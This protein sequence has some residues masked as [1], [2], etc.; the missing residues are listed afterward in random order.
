M[1]DPLGSQSLLNIIL[2]SSYR[3]RAAAGKNI[4]EKFY[5]VAYSMYIYIIIIKLCDCIWEI[6]IVNIF[7]FAN[8]EI[9]KNHRELY[10]DMKLSGM[11]KKNRNTVCTSVVSAYYS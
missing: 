7:N 11:I 3:S 1:I 4:T 6:C 2:V 10:T 9:C 5:E 8:V